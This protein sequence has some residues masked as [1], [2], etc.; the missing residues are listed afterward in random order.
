L[1]AQYLPAQHISGACFDS[2]SAP[3]PSQTTVRIKGYRAI[4]PAYSPTLST[5]YWSG[6]GPTVSYPDV[7]ASG[8][9]GINAAGFPKNQYVRPYL[10][11]N[12]TFVSGYWR[13]SP[14]DGLPTCEI[15]HC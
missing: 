2:A 15:I 14:T 10:R 8:F 5:H 4:D 3:L 11:S 13:N 6:A 9:G 7:Y 1:P 12:G